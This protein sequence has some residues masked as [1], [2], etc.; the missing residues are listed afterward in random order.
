MVFSLQGALRMAAVYAAAAVFASPLCADTDATYAALRAARP[1][2]RTIPVRQLTLERDA[3]RFQL[4]AGT[5][6]LLAPVNGRTFGAVFLGQGTFRLSPASPHELRQLALSSGGGEGFDGLTDSFED[7]LLLFTDDTLA[8]LER[9]APA[10]AGA[11]DPRAMAAF[12]DWLKRQRKDFKSNFHLHLLEDLL[13]PPSPA[14]GVFLALVNGRKTPLALA[15]V[16]PGGAEDLFGTSRTGGE[17]TLFW[18]ADQT[19]GGIWYLS[20]RK[21]ELANGRPTPAVQLADALDYR[22]ET[23]V[24]RDADLSGR[25]TV[26]FRSQVDGLRVLPVGLLQKL[27]ISEAAYAIEA[28]ETGEPSWRPLPWIQEDEKEDGDAAVV[29]PEP[30]AR[31]SVV[32]LRLAYKGGEVLQN[33]GGKSFVVS[34]RSSWYPNLGVFSDPAGFELTYRI[35]AGLDVVSVGR[36]VEERTEGKQRISTWRTDGPIQVAGF[37]YGKFERHER[38]DDES[39]FHVEVF[40]GTDRPNLGP[41]A[42]LVSAGR[43]ADGA[44]VDGVNAARVFTAYFGPLPQTRVAITQQAQWSFGQSW[45]S[46]IF[47]PYMSFLDGTQRQALGLGSLSDFVNQVGFHEFAHQWWGHLVGAATYRDQWLEE[48][49][50]EFSAAL[51]VQHTQGWPAYNDFWRDARKRIVGKYPGNAIV[52]YQAGPITQ[53]WRLG[54]VRT[55]SAPSAMM[56]SKGAYVLHMLRSAL[57]DPKAQVPDARFIALMTDFTKTYGGKTATTADFQKTVERHMTPALDIAGDGTMNWFFRQWVYGTDIPRYVADLKIDKLGGG[58]YRIHGQVTQEGVAPDFRAL[59]PI[60]LEFGKNDD[61]R[62]GMMRITGNATVPVDVKLKLP[63]APKRALVNPH[64]EVLA[65]D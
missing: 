60:A 63:K 19:R 48:G 43:L 11:P 64:G 44:A 61:A 53:G 27:R 34:A 42:G 46:L 57:W 3:F 37:N 36:K 8:E 58:E 23:E 51:A 9:Q 47:L 18:V 16:D 25:A 14:D 2:G 50:S 4:E 33:V 10:V 22:I 38:K 20:D 35:P 65:R 49:F 56:Y 54:T 32:R 52:H 5:L 21:E 28:G 62:I 13:A 30:L 55:P 29:F 17:D 40:T 39:G 45:P 31:G 41:E 24:E 15:A 26:R 12:E 7:L 6:H 1:D 59:V